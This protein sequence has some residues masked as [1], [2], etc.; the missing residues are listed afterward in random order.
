MRLRVDR[1]IGVAQSG[2]RLVH[3]HAE[4]HGHKLQARINAR[5]FGRW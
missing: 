5:T 2:A 3:S 4:W 1:K